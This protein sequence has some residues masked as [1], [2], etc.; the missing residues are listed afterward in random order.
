MKLYRKKYNIGIYSPVS[1]GET[2]LALV[3]NVSEF[4]E[5]L[6]VSVACASMI[7]KNIYTNKIKHIRYNHKLCLVEFIKED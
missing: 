6:N 5:L 7:L 4:A 2:L 3:D 1:D